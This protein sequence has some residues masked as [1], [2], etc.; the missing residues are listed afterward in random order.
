MTKI[1]PTVGRVVWFTPSRLTGDGRFALIDGRKPLAAIVAHVFNDGLV[2]LA[3]FD[4]NGTPHSR[5]SVPCAGRRGQAGARL[6]L[7]LD[8]LPGREGR[9]ACQTG[10][11]SP[12]ALAMSVDRGKADLA[13]G[14]AEVYAWHFSDLPHPVGNVR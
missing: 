14:R 1:L 4:S 10:I 3:G 2:N 7:L 6:F 12:V 11:S 8:A 9:E 5:T 13:L